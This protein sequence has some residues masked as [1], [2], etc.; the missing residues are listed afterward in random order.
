MRANMTE[1]TIDLNSVTLEELRAE[2]QS[3]MIVSD[4]A[5]AAAEELKSKDKNLEPVY[6]RIGD[7]EFLYRALYRKE[8]R[9]QIFE[10]NKRVAEAGDDQ[11][12][13]MEITEDAK[14]AMVGSAILWCSNE[15]EMP[16]GVVEVLSDAV[17]YES[18]FGPPETEPVKL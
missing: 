2:I 9:Q 5:K 3:R 13:I 11:A 14:E 1:Q 15:G 12:L 18:G 10:Q 17:L 8:W 6:I 4:E 7:R 16:A